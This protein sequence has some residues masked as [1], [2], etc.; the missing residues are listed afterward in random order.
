[1]DSYLVS[2]LEKLSREAISRRTK[3]YLERYKKVSRKARKALS[4]RIRR[5][6]TLAHN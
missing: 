3:R 4:R 1:M 5:L 2:Y 6:G